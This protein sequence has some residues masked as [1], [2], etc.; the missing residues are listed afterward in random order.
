MKNKLSTLLL[1]KML[2]VLGITISYFTVS[3]QKGDWA[4]FT[5]YKDA[6]SVDKTLSSNMRQ[7]IFMGNSITQGWYT[8]DSAFF[9]SNHYLGRGISGQTTSQMLVRFRKDV[10]DLSPKAVVILAGTND[11]AGNTGDIELQNIAGNLFSMAEL[12]KA[13]GIKV[14]LCSVLPAYDYPW[15]RG[16]EPYKKIPQL[17]Q[18]I[19]NYAKANNVTY[20]DF[21]TKMVD[22]RGGLSS[23][24]AKDGVHP[25]MQG[26]KIMEDII[27]NALKK[28]L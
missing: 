25:T 18:L 22:Q 24:L 16:K 10:L 13:H 8:M 26:Y 9:K 4:N 1:P 7:V 11:I 12:A 23:N 5:K 19:E 21:Y 20:V 2:L 27:L 28:S 14:F 3:A 17:N 6:N 15:S